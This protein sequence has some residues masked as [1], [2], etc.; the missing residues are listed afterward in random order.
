MDEEAGAGSRNAGVAGVAARAAQRHG[1]REAIEARLV[2]HGPSM[3]RL[4][5]RIEGMA[6]LW[7]P[8]LLRGEPGS[9]RATAA[10]L[11]HAWG[12]AARGE[13]VRIDAD[14]FAPERRLPAVATVLLESVE[15]LSRA[16]QAWWL[17][18]LRAAQAPG[19]VR[20]IRWLAS[21]G[22]APSLRDF[23]PDFDPAL[24]RI[25]ASFAI[26][27]PPLRE[28]LGDLPVL[29]ADLCARIGCSL[30]RERVRV[31]A[32]ALAVLASCHWPGNV[33][34]LEDVLRRAIAFTPS[35]RLGRALVADVLAE[36]GESV[37]GLRAERAAREREELLA[38][39]RA[40]AGNVARTAEAL[41]R[42]RSAVYR[43]IAKHRIP[44]SWHRGAA[45]SAAR[46]ARVSG[47]AAGCGPGPRAGRRR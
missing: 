4:R 17:D 8:V 43:L 5:Q 1:M 34:E 14:G 3:R 29:V 39:L 47:R 40:T 31:S 42:S 2:G 26:R 35:P 15:R 12:P 28:R 9:G 32:P 25:L 41:G 10:S 23:A 20:G 22:D 37:G 7:I 30:G 44:L 13:L 33:G 38:R 36:R 16:A 24:E 46:G 11:L 18:R 19:A 6:P 45:A 21:T 27:V